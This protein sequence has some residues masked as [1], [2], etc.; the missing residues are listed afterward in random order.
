MR[1]RKTSL[2]NMEKQIFNFQYQALDDTGLM[3]LNS[4]EVLRQQSVW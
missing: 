3:H 1:S 4:V 2:K